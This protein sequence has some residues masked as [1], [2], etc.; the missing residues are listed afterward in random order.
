MHTKQWQVEVYLSE[1]DDVTNAR[2]VLIGDGRRQVSA[3][4]HSRRNPRD[5]AVP[6]IGD[7]VAVSR[8]LE[9]LSRELLAVAYRDIDASV[10]D[11]F[12]LD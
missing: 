9:G 6:E 5:P 11:L 10:G 8:A 7:E 2:A 4:G 1:D 3:S 12:R